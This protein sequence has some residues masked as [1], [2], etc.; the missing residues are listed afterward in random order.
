MKNMERKNFIPVI[1]FLIL[2]SYFGFLFY[3]DK[4]LENDHDD[5]L[6]EWAYFH[7][8]THKPLFEKK[9]KIEKRTEKDK[10]DMIRL[11]RR[12][13]NLNEEWEFWYEDFT[14]HNIGEFDRMIDIQRFY[15]DK[16]GRTAVIT[17]RYYSDLDSED[18]FDPILLKIQRLITDFS[19][20]LE[21]DNTFYIIPVENR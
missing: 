3:Q 17:N 16:S 7:S 20:I 8:V 1:I 5:M 12:L 6:T 2:L 4:N 13:D 14:F 18:P 11:H 9:L 10:E 19:E 21:K 15:K